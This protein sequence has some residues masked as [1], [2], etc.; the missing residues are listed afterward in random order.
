M[1]PFWLGMLLMFAFALVLGLLPSYGVGSWQ[2]YVLPAISVG[3][4]SA[5]ATF[6]Y[7]RS[8]M[9]DVIRQE[10]IVTARVKGASEWRII[11]KHALKNALLPVITVLSLDFVSILG[12]SIATETLF[13]IPGIGLQL[14]TSIRLKDVPMVMGGTLVLAFLCAII[15]MVVDILYAFIDPRIKAKYARKG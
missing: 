12:G 3:L 6:R 2:H 1:P 5:A 10:Y 15:V 8:A 9:L 4:P 13:S 7:T 14:I 11:H